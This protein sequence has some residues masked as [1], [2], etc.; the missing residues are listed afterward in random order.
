MKPAADQLAAALAPI[1][2][3][4]L[5]APVITNVEATANRDRGRV[6]QLLIDQVTA[7]VRWVEIVQSLVASGETAAIEIGPNKVLM[8]LIRRIDRK[9]KVH[10]VQDVETLEKTLGEL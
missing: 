3:G 6:K 1:E 2:I 10:S 5:S 9:L 8:G 7:P 4:E